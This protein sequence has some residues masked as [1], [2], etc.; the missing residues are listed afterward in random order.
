V[1][2]S[3]NLNSKWKRVLL[4]KPNYKKLDAY[5]YCIKINFPPL[6]LAFIASYLLDLGIDVEIIDAKAKNLNYKELERKIRKFKPDL[7]G[8]SVFLTAVM[9]ECFKI[10]KIIK[11]IDPKITVVFGGKHPTFDSEQILK[12]NEVDIIVRGEGEITFRELITKGN[13]HN[14]EGISYRTKSLIVHNPNRQ[15]MDFSDVRLPARHLYNRNKYRVYT[16]GLETIESSRGCPYSCKFCITS[17]FYNSTWRPRPVERIITELKLISQNRRIS[18][19]F[20]I[21]DNFAANTKRIEKLCERIIECKKNNEINDFKFF[22]LIR[23]DSVVKSPQMIK[24][25]AKAGFWVLLIGIETIFDELLKDVGKNVSFQTVLDAIKI[26]HRNDIIIVGSMIIG[27]SLHEEEE[28]IKKEIEFM[29]NIDIDIVTFSILTPFPGTSTF[30]EL[31]EKGLLISKD[32]SNYTV[33]K[34]V[35]KTNKLSPKKLSELLLFSFQKIKYFNTIKESLLRLIRRR[36]LLFALN[37]V[38]IASMIKASIKIRIFFR[39]LRI[40]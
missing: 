13:P 12:R 17:N 21:D 9:N 11:Q 19:I 7:I 32:W 30:H 4:I 27:M 6:N 39:T 37:P 22:A 29:S 36:G 14:V 2:K 34:P 3:E 28:D 5:M 1:L 26:L 38:R 25:M 10:A 20:F 8:I 16:V 35:I 24:K 23:V 18:D 15:L 31:E 33:L 40:K